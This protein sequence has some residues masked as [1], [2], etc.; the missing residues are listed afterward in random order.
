MLLLKNFKAVYDL[1]GPNLTNVLTQGMT[2]KGIAP[3]ALA[4]AL[5]QAHSFEE[6]DDQVWE[7]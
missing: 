6:N 4:V 2:T 5:C 1:N 3:D 7:R